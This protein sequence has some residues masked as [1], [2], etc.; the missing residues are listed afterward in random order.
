MAGK[1]AGEVLANP[2]RPDDAPASTTDAGLRLGLSNTW[3]FSQTASKRPAR[4]RALSSPLLARW[5]MSVFKMT[6]QRPESGAALGTAVQSS[7]ACSMVRLKRST[8]WRRKLPVPCEQREF[9]RNTS[10]PFGR[11]SSTEKPW[12]PMETTV[13]GESPCT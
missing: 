5:V 13:V 10:A 12:A 4:M 1:K 11:S 9:S 2:R 8:S 3:T 7:E 6:G